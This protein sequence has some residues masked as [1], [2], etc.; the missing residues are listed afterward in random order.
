MQIDLDRVLRSLPSI[1]WTAGCNGEVDFASQRWSNYTGQRHEDALGSAWQQAFHPRDLQALQE[2]WQV[3]LDSRS[4]GEFTAR[5]GSA[6]GGFRLLSVQFGPIRDDGGKV[7]KWCAFGSDAPNSLCSGEHSKRLVDLSVLVANMPVPAIVTLPSGE[8]ETANQ[9]AHDDLGDR[10]GGFSRWDAPAARSGEPEHTLVGSGDGWQN[11]APYNSESRHRRRDGTYRWFN[12][13]GLPV[14]DDEGHA[15]R[16]LHLLVD[17]N[18]GKLAEGS[19]GDCQR[20]AR[21]LVDCIPVGIEVLSPDGKPEFVNAF[22][23][24]YFG[25]SVAELREAGLSPF[26]HPQDLPLV[27]EASASSTQ[28]GAPFDME[29]RFLHSSGNYRWFHVRGSPLRDSTGKIVRWYAVHIDIDDQKRAEYALLQSDFNSKLTVNNIPAMAWSSRPDGAA[30]FL[31]QYYLDYIGSSAPAAEGWQWT[32]AVHPDDLPGLI[33]KWQVIM[34]S[35]KSGEA[36]AR[37]RRFDGEYRWFLFRGYPLRDSSSNIVKWY[38]VNTDIDDLKRAEANLS[39]EKH[40]LEIIASGS[41]VREVLS[42]LCAFVEESTTHC[43]CDIHPIDWSVPAIEYSV[44]PSLPAEYTE[45]IAGVSLSGDGIPC[46]IAAREKIQVVAEDIDSD[47]RWQ[48]TPVRIHVLK[49]GLRSVW[50]TP[51]CTKDGHVLG[52]LCLYQRQPAVPSAKHQNIIAHATHIASIAIE[53]SRTEAALRRS[54]TVLTEAQQLSS[55]GSFSWLVDTE[56]VFFSRE[57]YRIFEYEHTEPMTVAKVRSRV[58]PEDLPLLS[59][60]MARVRDG[61]SYIGYEIRLR[62]PDERVKN[63]RTFGRVITHQ[64]GQLECL[65]AV[66]DTTE[67]RAADE[68]LGKARAELAHVSRVSSLAVLTASIAHE[69]NQPLAGIITNANTCLRF[70][71]NDPPNIDSARETARRTIRDGSRAADVIARLRALFSNRETEFEAVDLNAAVHEVLALLRGELQRG[72]VMVSTDLDSG[73]HRVLGDRIQL[74]QVIMNLVRNALDAMVS[75]CDRPRT[76]AI[77]TTHLS[78]GQVQLSVRD[79]GGGFGPE[80]SGRIFDPF[81]TTKNDGMGIGLSVCR[82]IVQRH[83]GFLWAKENSEHGVTLAFSM[84]P[85]FRQALLEEVD[86]QTG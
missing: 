85:Y 25:K 66:Q 44:A 65:A 53:R 80:G 35:G 75:V 34:A 73:L 6:D 77:A 4:S 47:P 3:L 8:I 57:L 78:D 64:D 13:L 46:A 70:L 43:Y 63:V 36:E 24:R 17:I 29:F 67:L 50:S 51:I 23:A 82:S 72:R 22:A 14:T 79:S 33:D 27:L 55:T 71:A 18:E 39:R 28:T 30:D 20:E 10:F 56:K 48:N 42:A 32:S 69:V 38:G 15:S 31:S 68:A 60:Q 40:L 76:L 84:P 26:I 21:Q 2:R 59:A 5:V 54:E 9:L 45:P 49:H 62:M 1:L 37:I 19:L 61:Q 83:N 81:Y 52:T 58:H 12:T 86:V 11:R 16:W 7:V 74:Q 41:P